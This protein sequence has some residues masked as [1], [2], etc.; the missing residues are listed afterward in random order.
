M[1][2]FI[3]I[4]ACVGDQDPKTNFKDGFTS[5]IKE[6][7]NFKDERIILIEPNPA[8]IDALKKC[9]NGYKH[10]EIY[11]IGLVP[12]N[13]DN[14]YLDFYYSEKDEPYYL[15]AS[16][17]INH[18][19]KSF[20]N[21]KILNKKIKVEKIN[22][23]FNQQVKD[24]EV[25]YLAID[26]E[27]LDLKLLISLDLNKFNIKNISIEV[28]HFSK[29]EKRQLINKMIE[30]GYSFSGKG[31][32]HQGFDYMFTRKLNFFLKLKTKLISL[33]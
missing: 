13:V 1:S 9:W 12:D 23:F 27:G 25:S 10:S 28:I 29:K 11:N 21:D 26:A 7:K 19:I 14:D 20:P 30:N 3:Q 31:F 18:V 33:L 2:I 15:S 16:F 17:D 32:D 6:N 22:K 4:G 8:N 24:Q 5:F